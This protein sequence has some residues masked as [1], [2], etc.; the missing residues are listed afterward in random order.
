MNEESYPTPDYIKSLV[1]PQRSFEEV[2]STLL[3]GGNSKL[4]SD[5]I[6]ELGNYLVFNA[7]RVGNL[8]LVKFLLDIKPELL[9]LHKQ[10]NGADVLENAVVSGNLELVIYLISCGSDPNYRYFMETSILFFA[11]KHGHVDIF[12]YLVEEFHM[13]PNSILSSAG[14][15]ALYMAM[16]INNI[17]LFDYLLS[18]NPKLENIGPYNYL[19]R[20]CRMDDIYCLEELLKH[21]APFEVLEP[22]NMSPF[23][24]SGE[25]NNHKFMEL[26]L[27]KA[28][29]VKP[30]IFTS[31]HINRITHQYNA[32][33]Y[34]WQ[35]LYDIYLVRYYSELK[36]KEVEGKEESKTLL[37]NESL[38]RIYEIVIAKNNSNSVLFKVPKEIF[39]CAMSY[40][41]DC[42]PK[43]N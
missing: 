2:K 1:N 43:F 3:E 17:G 35:R 36:R 22:Y 30:E 5:P 25:E 29:G 4:I 19:L 12:K 10:S 18:F 7:A 20:A 31:P 28:K 6:D 26:I 27:K 24:A 40:L 13:D 41:Y 15:T 37:V 16:E 38:E 23:S 21:K 32:L 34:K 8:P 9:N 11:I 39:K 14:T 33:C 42:P